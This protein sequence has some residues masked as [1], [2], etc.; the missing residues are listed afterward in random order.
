MPIIKYGT[1]IVMFIVASSATLRD[2]LM[3]HVAKHLVVLV[4]G[5]LGFDFVSCDMALHS[6]FHFTSLLDR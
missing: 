6:I 2:R 4:F 5:I 1:V 3:S